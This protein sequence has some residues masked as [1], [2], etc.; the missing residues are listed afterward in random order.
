M[1][2]NIRIL[3][4]EDEEVDHLA[5]SRMVKEKNLPYELD[6]AANL[7]EALKLLEERQYDVVLI[8][9]RLPD[10]TGLDVLGR[11]KDAVGIFITGSGDERVAVNAMKGGAYDY[12]IKEPTGGYLDLLPTV[13]D[14]ALDTARLKK[15]K[16]EAEASLREKL[17]V[18][19]RLN[20]LLVQSNLAMHTI[21]EDNKRLSKRI[22]ELERKGE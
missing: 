7:A 6:R 14:R 22:E 12:I 18:V 21:K 10:G 3:N 20:K 9:Y 15:E 17:D 5:V 13:I 11:L 8:D 4:I 1:A 16:E 2:E 19:E